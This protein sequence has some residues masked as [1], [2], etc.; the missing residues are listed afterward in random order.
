[1]TTAGYV[2]WA[3]WVVVNSGPGLTSCKVCREMECSRSITRSLL[4]CWNS[5]GSLSL[6][7]Q[8]CDCLLWIR[9]GRAGREGLLL[10][11]KGKKDRKENGKRPCRRAHH[12]NYRQSGLS[13]LDGWKPFPKSGALLSEGTF[14]RTYRSIHARKKSFNHPCQDKKEQS[15]L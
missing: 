1:M 9:R 8:I 4:I 10:L 11:L 13:Q 12:K 7:E 14:K 3:W 5:P 6:S 2:C 15:K